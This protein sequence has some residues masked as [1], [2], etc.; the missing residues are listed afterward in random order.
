[1]KKI[2]IQEMGELIKSFW[3]PLDL[4]QINDIKVRLVK[5]KGKYH[6]HKHAEEDEIFLVVEGKMSIHFK[7]KDIS[8]SAKEAF[9]VPKNVEHLTES[10]DGALVMLIEPA[11]IKTSG[12]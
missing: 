5:I 1:M 11:G 9:L 12:D 8:L 3:A 10:Q 2:S 4:F 7:D 6:W